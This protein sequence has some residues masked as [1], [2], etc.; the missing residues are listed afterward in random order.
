[1]RYNSQEGDK[2]KI[3]TRNKDG[4]VCF[5][6]QSEIAGEDVYV[7]LLKDGKGK[8]RIA[9]GRIHRRNELFLEHVDF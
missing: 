4:E 8:I 7:T 9:Q 2:L 3:K 5:N 1:M 6:P